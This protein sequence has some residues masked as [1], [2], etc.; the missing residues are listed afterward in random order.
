[1]Y[2]L[3][4]SREQ[5]CSDWGEIVHSFEGEDKR[6]TNPVAVLAAKRCGYSRIGLKIENLNEMLGMRW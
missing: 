1:M 6:G 2:R 5:H 4:G 3:E